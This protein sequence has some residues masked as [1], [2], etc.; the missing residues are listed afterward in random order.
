MSHNNIT[1]L[2]DKI[3]ALTV[4]RDE[5]LNGEHHGSK[6]VPLLRMTEKRDEAKAEVAALKAELLAM[7]DM[8]VELS[9][10]REAEV[11]ALKVERDEA[12]EKWRRALV[13]CAGYADEVERLLAVCRLV[14]RSRNLRHGSPCLC[15]TCEDADRAVAALPVEAPGEGTLAAT[16][17]SFKETSRAIVDHLKAVADPAPTTAGGTAGERYST[18]VPGQG[19]DEALRH[20]RVLLKH[21]AVI[22]AVSGL[23][24]DQTDAC[25]AADCFQRRP[26]G[27]VDAAGLLLRCEEWLNPLRLPRKESLETLLRDLRAYREN[28][29]E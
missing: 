17:A 20:L 14:Q 6:C 3:I 1:A 15:V 25:E 16:V 10:V 22:K 5:A 13:D 4:E 28:K 26:T 24:I 12:W 23:T 7:D 18:P 19:N 21:M 8:A 11:A 29:N 2:C 9:H 27:Q